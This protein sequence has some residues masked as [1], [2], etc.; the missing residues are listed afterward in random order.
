MAAKGLRTLEFPD[1]DNGD[2]L[3]RMQAGG[4]DLSCPRNI[5]FTVVFATETT[6]RQFAKHFH[7]QGYQASVELTHTA[8]SFPWDVVVVKTMIPTHTDI[9]GF[10][11]ELQTVAKS[12]GGHNDGWGCF[13]EKP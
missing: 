9:G 7:E 1:D 5:D 6:A 4:D 12:L 13:A 11:N 8:E 3:R 2:V 10:E